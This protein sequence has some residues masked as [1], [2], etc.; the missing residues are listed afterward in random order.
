MFTAIFQNFY[1]YQ[2]IGSLKSIKYLNINAEIHNNK[3]KN[4]LTK[5]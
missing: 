1:V 2:E 3:M 5:K 4:A